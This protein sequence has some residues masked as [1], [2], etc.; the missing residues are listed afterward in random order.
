MT[1][2]EVNKY[3]S[4]LEAK[5]IVLSFSLAPRNRAGIAIQSVP[6]ALDEVQL[7]GERELA[8]LN[9]KRDSV[10][11]QEVK[12]AL[13]RIA[14]GSYGICSHCKEDLQLKRL[15]AAPWAQYCIRCDNIVKAAEASGVEPEP[16]TEDVPAATS[17]V[18]E[19]GLGI[20]RTPRRRRTVLRNQPDV[21]AN[22]RSGMPSAPSVFSWI[23]LGK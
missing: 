9:L 21:M 1:Q 11:L 4:M 2:T 15:D 17:K 19:N 6:D 18:F 3:K 23:L 20:K 16:P 22:V 14:D 7:A 5:A 10:L 13:A 12:A 8:I